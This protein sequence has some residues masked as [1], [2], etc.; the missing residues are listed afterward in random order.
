[1]NLCL[2]WSQHILLEL[3]LLGLDLPLYPLIPPLP[4]VSGAVGSKYSS[5]I[6]FIAPDSQNTGIAW[7][8]RNK[9]G[10]FSFEHCTIFVSSEVVAGLFSWCCLKFM[11]YFSLT[12]FAFEFI[13]IL[14][15]QTTKLT[16][17][18]CCC[19]DFVFKYSTMR[20]Y[21]II[22]QQKQT[23]NSSKEAK[24]KGSSRKVKKVAVVKLQLK[25]FNTG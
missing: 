22:V 9:Y 15:C 13:F 3:L 8:S 14:Y 12:P 21:L 7:F 20:P 1:M 19:S 25:N 16:P 10:S 17:S 18:L 24:V 23:K 4:H 11:A 2:Q 5:G 6:V